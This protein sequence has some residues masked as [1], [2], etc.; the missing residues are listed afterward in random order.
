M[1]TKFKHPPRT[2]LIVAAILCAL[3][4]LP[5]SALAITAA[6]TVIR[7]TATVTWDTAP[8][9]GVSASV[10]VT[11]QLVKAQPTVAW[12]STNPDPVAQGGNATVTYTLTSTANGR[13]SYTLASSSTTDTAIGAPVSVTPNGSPLV[14]GASMIL[15]VVDADTIT[16]AGTTSNNGLADGDTVMI[17][18][19]P[20][21]LTF[22]SED[23]SVSVNT[24]TFDLDGTPGASVGTAVYERAN[25]TVTVVA[26]T[27]D[28]PTIAGSHTLTTTA[29]NGVQTGSDT[30]GVVNVAPA[31]LTLTKTVDNATPVPTDTITYTLVVTNTSGTVAASSVVIVDPVPAY[32]TYVGS[33]VT[34]SGG[35]GT[36]DFSIDGSTYGTAD[37]TTARYV[38][39]TYATLAAGASRTITFQVTID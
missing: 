38:R 27:L 32:T 6:Q 3:C 12:V 8:A 5:T 31:S 34:D 16:V 35:D 13:D 28:T 11:V 24:S 23:T 33:S 1:N 2:G 19:S 39:V 10:D 26:G 36:I 22:V 18:G 4:V 7:N 15:A 20:Y 25:F 30:N 21:V 17:G 29:S 37:D 9:G 14:V